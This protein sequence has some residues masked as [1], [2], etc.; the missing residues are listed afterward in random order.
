MEEQTLHLML[1]ST[2]IRC[3]AEYT[4]HNGEYIVENVYAKVNGI[5]Y[6]MNTIL[7]FLAQDQL[8]K[9]S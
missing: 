6:N 1:N 5:E 8:N 2:R 9:K 3:R 7:L 4:I